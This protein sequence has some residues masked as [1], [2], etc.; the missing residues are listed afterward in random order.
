MGFSHIKKGSELQDIW[1]YF[2]TM[3]SKNINVC[4]QQLMAR[5]NK[6][7]QDHRIPIESSV[8]LEGTTIKAIMELKFNPGEGVAHLS[9]ADKGLSIM[10]CQSRTSTDTEQIREHK[11]ALS[12]TENTGQSD[13]LLHLSK[14]VT[15]APADNFWKL[16]INIAM[17]MS[18]AWVLFGSECDYYKGLHNVYAMLELKEVMAQKNSFTPE[19]CR[20]I[21]WV[22][23]DD[24]RAHFDDVKPTL[25]F[26]GPDNPTFLQ[27]YL[28]DILRNVR[29]AIPVERVNF[30]NKWKWKNP[31]PTGDP[32]AKG[33]VYGSG[34]QRG[35]DQ[36]SQGMDRV[37][38]HQDVTMDRSRGMGVGAYRVNR[39]QAHIKGGGGGTPLQGGST[40]GEMRI[41]GGGAPFS[42]KFPPGGYVLR[43]W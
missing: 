7:A 39:D 16:K 4:R 33:A 6:W 35:G 36:S 31:P 29:Y 21:T 32:G 30:P 20:K 27:S 43:D 38:Q 28:I 10:A 37:Q 18:L 26:Q 24:G 19:H 34:Q 9:S 22:I 42:G 13:E 17:F 41:I 12:T 23:L 40:K 3:R 14:G 15:C 11:E 2:H 8:Y 25:D 1:S 5:M